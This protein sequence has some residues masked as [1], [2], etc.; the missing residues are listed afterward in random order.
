M[1]AIKTNK[2]LSET[3][4]NHM[5]LLHVNRLPLIFLSSPD[6]I[7]SSMATSWFR[8]EYQFVNIF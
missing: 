6:S 2:L 1:E 3:T 8:Q 7:F 4:H 5:G